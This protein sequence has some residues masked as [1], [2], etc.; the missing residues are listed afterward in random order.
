[1]QQY[2]AMRET[3]HRVFWNEEQG[4]WFDY[5]ISSNSHISVYY[6]TNFFPLFT[7]CTHDGFDGASIV[8]YLEKAVSGG[9]G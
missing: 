8:E 6:D 2:D 4:C 9:G 5:D 7:G 3:I 1:M